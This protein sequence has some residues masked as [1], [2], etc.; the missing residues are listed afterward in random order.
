M[1]KEEKKLYYFDKNLNKEF[2]F[3]PVINNKNNISLPL[4]NQISKLPNVIEGKILTNIE[5][6]NPTGW[7]SEVKINK[8]DL[9]IK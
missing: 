9:V 7:W 5:G 1:L 3:I 6:Y 8:D 4:E 2:L